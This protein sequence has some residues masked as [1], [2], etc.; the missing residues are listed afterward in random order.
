GIQLNEEQIAAVRHGDGP[1]LTLASAGTGKTTVLVARTAYLIAVRQV[2]PA[3]I[4]L[5][6]F[7]KKAADEMRERIAR[8][9]LV[10]PMRARMVQTSTFHSFCLTILRS[11]NMVGQIMSSERQK[12]I[13]M[14]KAMHKLGLK[15]YEPE[16]IL[17]LYSHYRLRGETLQNMPQSTRAQQDQL[18]LFRAYEAWKAQQNVVDFDDLLCKTHEL[19]GQ[20][21]GLLRI[22]QDRFQYCMV[23]EFQ[24][25]NPLQYEIVEYIAGERANLFVVGDD[26]QTIY[27]FQGADSRIILD[28]DK[29][30]KGTTT[31]TLR[32]NY[33]SNQTILGLANA[34]IKHNK[35]R[36]PKTLRGVKY[37][38]DF[39]VIVTPPTTDEE[40]QW[41][42]K[43]IGE[44]VKN[45]TRTW[46][47]F[48]ILYRTASSAR[49]IAEELTL[50]RLPFWHASAYDSLFYDHW[51]I[52]PL[53]AMMNY[54]VVPTDV[55][56]IEG[57]VHTFYIA[58]EEAMRHIE[59]QQTMRPIEYPLKHLLTY[60]ALKSFQL[61]KVEERIAWLQKMGT[62]SPE[63][64]IRSARMQF[65][66]EFVET[67]QE[68]HVSTQKE[69]LKEMLN[70]TEQSAKR[71]ET[72]GD[73]LHFI[74]MYRMNTAQSKQAG[75]TGDQIT[76][77]TIH[78]AKGL[79]W[80]CVF[81]IGANDN[82]LPHVAAQKSGDMK[83]MRPVMKKTDEDA[84][85][86][87]ERRLMYVAITRAKEDLYLSSPRFYQGQV[88]E[89][90]RFID[91][92][93]GKERK[94]ETQHDKKQYVTVRAYVCTTP[95]CK[96]FKRIKATDVVS[97][98]ISCPFCKG[99][100]LPGK[101]KI[102][103]M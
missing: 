50:R 87:E 36:K 98:S 74:E 99:E 43:E 40:A 2:N 73:F 28:F 89:I 101:K 84:A 15:E 52:R 92:A 80:P 51:V 102:E 23:D 47:D 8:L 16:E 82:N 96:G 14:K 78:R 24:D 13:A 54:T 6:T 41:V 12:E 48:A 81:V 56:A 20:D 71:F 57:F 49:A 21:P 55:R 9:S 45:G 44:K 30:F 97:P 59:Q 91:E 64:F 39:P 72:L 10:G 18:R 95:N 79:E 62:Q 85:I 68:K 93:N 60:P 77:M 46:G 1:C 76:L 35:A 32:T 29:Q 34:V 94:K 19:L 4:L 11:R 65:Y 27:T 75:Q 67:Q 26:D 37:A 53:L 17:A 31:I 103:L 88:T 5:V 22:L 7:T 61:R 66:D 25:T 86:E 63:A 42:V 38:N 3:N 83:D 58:R 70:E 90:S 69:T 100:M 33:R